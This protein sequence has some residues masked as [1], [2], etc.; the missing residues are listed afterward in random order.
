MF[1]TILKA[2]VEFTP[3]KTDDEL[4]ARLD[5]FLDDNPELVAVV[6]K[7][8]LQTLRSKSE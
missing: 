4:L 7:F 6:F 2:A 5:E 3:T 8:F 1:M